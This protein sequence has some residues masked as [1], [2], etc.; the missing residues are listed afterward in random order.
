VGEVI[1]APQLQ[2]I[3]IPAPTPGLDPSEPTELSAPL[4]IDA[5]IASLKGAWQARLKW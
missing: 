2:I 4:V 5:D 3:G 1:A